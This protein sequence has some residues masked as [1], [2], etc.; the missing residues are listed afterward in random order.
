VEGGLG[1]TGMEVIRMASGQLV[2]T[3]NG[4]PVSECR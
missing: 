4:K 1:L 3:T 2:V